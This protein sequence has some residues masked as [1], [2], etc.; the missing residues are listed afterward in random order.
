[1]I[2]HTVLEEERIGF[3]NHVNEVLKQDA[4]IGSRLPISPKEIFE[5]IE[6]G[7]ILW[8]PL[9]YPANSSIPPPSARC[10]PFPPKPSTPTPNPSTKR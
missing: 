5:Q 2:I 3:T 1:M 8:Y 10:P 9:P 7:V 6:D 4:D